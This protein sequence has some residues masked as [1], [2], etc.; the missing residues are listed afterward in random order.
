ML[1]RRYKQAKAQV[2]EK[3]PV[4]KAEEPK[5]ETPKKPRKK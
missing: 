3:Q 4:A 5:V 2:V 1:L